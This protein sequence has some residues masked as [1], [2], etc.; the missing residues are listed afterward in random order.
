MLLSTTANFT[1]T[2]AITTP[3]TT[4]TIT[5]TTHLAEVEGVEAELTRAKLALTSVLAEREGSAL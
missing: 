1:I 5:I 3:T 4:T 2:I